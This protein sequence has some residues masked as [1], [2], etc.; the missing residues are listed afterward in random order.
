MSGSVSRRRTRAGGTPGRTRRVRRL[1]R[2]ATSSAPGRRAAK[3]PCTRRSMEGSRLRTSP[4]ECRA[5]IHGR[6][7]IRD[8]HESCFLR[9]LIGHSAPTGNGANPFYADAMVA[10]SG[11]F[12]LG[13]ARAPDR[14][15]S[16]EI[17]RAVNAAICE[18]E[19]RLDR[20]EPSVYCVGFLCECGCLSIAANHHDRVPRSRRSPGS[21][22][23]GPPD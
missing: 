2:R 3:L 11:C 17:A 1:C 6:G 19:G 14:R 13:W 10:G 22:A 4:Q 20:Q 9:V 16:A 15:V 12:L 18:L 21:P 5:V 23:T 8:A 7:T